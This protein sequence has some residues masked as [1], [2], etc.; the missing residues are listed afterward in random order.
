MPVN[1]A[2][3]SAAG[4]EAMFRARRPFELP[5]R[6]RMQQSARALTEIRRG[7]RPFRNSRLVRFASPVLAALAVAIGAEV[8]FAALPPRVDYALKFRPIEPPRL[9]ITS[10]AA[11][12]R[13]IRPAEPPIV[14]EPHH[15]DRES[16]AIPPEKAEPRTAVD[17]LQQPPLGE[18]PVAPAALL[19]P[20]DR[21]DATKHA[22]APE[23]PPSEAEAK[24][25]SPEDMPAVV[26]GAVP[27]PPPAVVIPQPVFAAPK[28]PEPVVFGP[29]TPAFPQPEDLAPKPPAAAR[30]HQE[31]AQHQPAA[32]R[33]APPEDRPKRKSQPKPASSG[34]LDL[35][36]GSSAPAKPMDN[37]F[38]NGS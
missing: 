32:K 19:P 37:Y 20:P 9:E 23:P 4:S 8:Y 17:S 27:A 16:P 2:A 1:N 10:L 24:P 6:K 5:R 35:F 38:S 28:A 11:A 18:Q 13:T 12:W 22:P 36:G 31:A 21:P 34:A 26:S 7:D 15:P 14:I 29:H 3:S 33:Q 25:E 30:K